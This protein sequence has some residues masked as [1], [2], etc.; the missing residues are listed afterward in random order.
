MTTA[1]NLVF[2][3][4]PDGHLVA[5][6]A[7]KGEKLLDIQTGL[8]GGM[9]PPIEAGMVEVRGGLEPGDEV[10]VFHSNFYRHGGVLTTQDAFLQDNDLVAVTRLA[11]WIVDAPAYGIVSHPIA[12]HAMM[13]IRRFW[14]T[15]SGGSSTAIA[16]K[17]PAG[18][19]TVSVFVVLADSSTTNPRVQYAVE[20]VH[21]EA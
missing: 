8:R 16:A 7:D 5:H 1:G 18:P 12:S 17:V 2:Q 6:T 3:V 21:P 9:G 15:S 20:E 13:P 4:I 14:K 19:A 10:V 11:A